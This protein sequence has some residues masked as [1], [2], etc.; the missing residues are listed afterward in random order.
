MTDT[1]R[2][3]LIEHYE[4]MIEFNDMWFVAGKFGLSAGDTLREALDGAL[5]AQIKWSFAACF[6]Q[7]NN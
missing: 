2:L 1:E 4:W 5:A 7:D 6:I 3:N